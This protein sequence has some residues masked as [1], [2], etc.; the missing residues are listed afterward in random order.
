MPKCFPQET[1][2]ILAENGEVAPAFF[3]SNNNMLMGLIL[4]TTGRPQPLDCSYLHPVKAIMERLWKESGE[5]LTELNLPKFFEMACKEYDMNQLK[6]G[7]SILAAGFKLD[8]IGSFNPSATLPG[9][10][11]ADLRLAPTAVQKERAKKVGKAAGKSLTAK[12]QEQVTSTFMG[13]LPEA[14]KALE[15]LGGRAEAIR[16]ANYGAVKGDK[17]ESFDHLGM[18]TGSETHQLPTSTLFTARRA[19]KEDVKAKEKQGKLSVRETIKAKREKLFAEKKAWMAT[20]LAMAAADKAQRVA[21]MAA[22]K[23][24]RA[25]MAPGRPRVWAKVMW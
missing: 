1:E 16:N 15:P 9:T 11:A 25:A 24:T 4:S 22:R 19:R 6:S 23:A 18:G 20:K 7:K 10:H 21:A 5:I 14:A 8:I 17:E 12:V 13:R 3:A 2:D